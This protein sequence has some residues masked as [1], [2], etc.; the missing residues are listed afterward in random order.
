MHQAP[1]GIADERRAGIAHER[2]GFA[3]F[4]PLQQLRHTLFLVVLVIGNKSRF[5]P[6]SR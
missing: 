4:E 1:T 5:R 2:H 3:A 6:D